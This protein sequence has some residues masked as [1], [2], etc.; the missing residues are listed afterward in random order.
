MEAPEVSIVFT[1]FN[2]KQ[3]LRQAL[4]SLLT[5][6]FRNFELIIV[7]DC[8]TDGSQE[9]LKEY[10]Q[11]D[12]RIRLT[13]NEK[14]SGSYV[15]S[16][17]QG[18]LMATAPYIIFEQCDDWAE[19]NQIERLMNEM[20]ENNVGVVYSCS[21]MVDEE[22]RTMGMDFDGREKAFKQQHSKDSVICGSEAKEYLLESCIIPNLS[23]ALIKKDLFEELKGL[24]DKFVV[25]ADWDFWLRASLNCDFYYIREPLNNFRQHAATIRSSVK[26]RRQVGEVY[27]MMFNLSGIKQISMTQ[28]CHKSASLCIRWATNG[29]CEWLKALPHLL[30]DGTKQSTYFPI[31]FTIE[32]IKIS[33]KKVLTLCK[34]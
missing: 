1:S 8:S 22:G 10:A 18:A 11:K 20:R 13:L 17:N 29:W 5:Q 33:T 16:T 32:S 15:H 4:D 14:N 21:N 26:I 3:Y 19:P 9:V 28:A 34:K 27:T 23:A 7:D 12:E 31:A 24:S 25:L 6:T 30:W 2:H